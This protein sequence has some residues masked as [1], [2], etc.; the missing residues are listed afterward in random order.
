[1]KSIRRKIGLL[2][3]LN[4]VF[5]V[6]S[7]SSS[8]HRK[9]FQDE[10]KEKGFIGDFYY[11]GENRKHRT[12]I[13]LGGSEGGIPWRNKRGKKHIKEFVNLGY[14][15]L[16]LAYF[17]IEGLPGD[18]QEISLEYFERVFLWLSNNPKVVPNQYALIGASKGA[19]LAL[20]LASRHNEIKTT[21]AISP[22]SVMFQGIPNGPPYVR[23]SWS[24]HGK[25]L[26]Y[27]SWGGLSLEIL[28]GVY[29]KNFYSI[30]KSA[31]NN[32]GDNPEPVIKVENSNGPILLFS[33]EQDKM[34]PAK[35]MSDQIVRRLKINQ[36]KY[37]FEHI[38]YK[39]KGHRL[40]FPETQKKINTFLIEHFNPGL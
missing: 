17:K 24:Y 19:E 36:F 40:L 35:E 14:G 26:P 39:D 30:Y 22:S 2:L 34:W 16:S 28:K 5:L 11:D 15:V 33:G 38:A 18:L 21:I 4:T 9:N 37:F 13:V 31:L 20:L 10:L 1:M 7:C 12:I 29:T 8:F 23:S 6:I 32:M 3:T 27:A 25:E